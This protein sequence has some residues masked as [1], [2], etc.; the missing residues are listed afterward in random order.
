MILFAFDDNIGMSGE[1]ENNWDSAYMGDESYFGE[2]PSL[3]CVRSVDAFKSKGLS[4]ILELGAGQGRDTKYLIDNG[5]TVIATDFSEVSC[6]QLSQKFGDRITVEKRDLRQGIDLPPCSIDGCYA[7]ML[8]TMDFT[9]D[10]LKR[11]MSDIR[12]ILVPEGLFVFSVRNTNDHDYETGDI[13]R[14]SVWKNPKGFNVRYF[15]ND[16]IR[17]FCEG[18]EIVRMNEFSEGNKVLYGITLMKPKDQ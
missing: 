10:E 14:D 3:F 2:S 11:L 8:L 16:D 13:V 6:A 4:I 17:K 7:H 5:L 18:F 9:D 1:Q 12:R 15:S